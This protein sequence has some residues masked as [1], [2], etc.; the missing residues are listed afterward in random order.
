VYSRDAH[1]GVV[2]GYL[3]RQACFVNLNCPLSTAIMSPVE[4]KLNGTPECSTMRPQFL[5]ST[6]IAFIS[7]IGFL[8]ALQLAGFV[9][10]GIAANKQKST[11][12]AIAVSTETVSQRNVDDSL[13]LSSLE[14]DI[15]LLR[16]QLK[17]GVR[18]QDQLQL[19]LKEVA[20]LREQTRELD[21]KLAQAVLSSVESFSD[22]SVSGN[23]ASDGQTSALNE[24]GSA[25]QWRGWG[26]ESGD[27]NQTYD[28]LVG[29][30]V[31]PLVAQD[32]KFRA[33]QFSLQRLDLIDQA[34]REGWRDSDE[35]D[36]RMSEL[37]EQRPDIRAE[38]GD[39]NY[40]R[41]RYQTG[42]DNRVQ[43]ASVI[44]GSAASLSGL[45]PGDMVLSYAGQRVFSMRELQNATRD[46][47]RGEIVS[48]E[49]SRFGQSVTVDLER[50][51]LG[52][53][54][55]SMRQEPD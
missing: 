32:I 34:S 33:D 41:Y 49:V 47:S 20:E 23:L 26:N 2:C 7:G 18:R 8:F 54:L 3:M 36:Q 16:D 45:Q 19:A 48:V 22:S 55:E 43:L 50:G 46:G 5:I 24:A 13:L 38:L 44:D 53:T 42:R 27:S 39:E 12:D 6:A 37:R 11:G 52:V 31:D 15:A 40:D 29:A 28:D 30:G 10:L 1:T 9:T 35:F 17:Q 14:A 51:P 21:E 4:T 25:Q